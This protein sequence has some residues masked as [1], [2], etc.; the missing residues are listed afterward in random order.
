[1]TSVIDEERDDSG[2]SLASRSTVRRDWDADRAVVE[3]YVAHYHS[4]LVYA[5]ALVK[6][7][8]TAE[9]VVQDAFVVLH[10]A[11]HRLKNPQKAQAYL[12]TVVRNESWSALRRQ[13]DDRLEPDDELDPGVHSDV[14]SAE[15]EAVTNFDTHA[16]LTALRQLPRRQRETLALTI[17]GYS[18][19]EVARGLGIEVNAVRVNLHHARG[20]VRAFLTA[21]GVLAAELPREWSR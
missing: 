7:R 12:R 6:N 14:I 1:V 21:A 13:V 3:L 8:A 20:K 5:M 19:I 11:W 16:V 2:R 10:G 15:D 17:D 4:L 9:D 18:T